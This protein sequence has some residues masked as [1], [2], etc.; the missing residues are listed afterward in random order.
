M[1]P[2]F[3]SARLWFPPAE[4]AMK[5]ALG[6]GTSHWPS[7]LFPQ[8]TMELLARR[9]RQWPTNMETST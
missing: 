6:G 9:P 3:L 8:A 5:L 4:T 1:E 7:S 2:S